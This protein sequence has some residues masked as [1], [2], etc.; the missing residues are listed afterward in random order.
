[1]ASCVFSARQIV[2]STVGWVAPWTA[3]VVLAPRF[4]VTAVAFSPDGAAVPWKARTSRSGCGTPDGEPVTGVGHE[5][6]GAAVAFS[7]R[8]SVV[9]VGSDGTVRLWACP[10]RWAAPN[11]GRPRQHVTDGSRFLPTAAAMLRL[12]GTGMLQLWTLRTGSCS[13]PW[14]PRAKVEPV[15]FSPYAA[16]VA[17]VEHGF[18]LCSFGT[19]HTGEL[20]RTWRS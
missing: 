7:P 16:I 14:P 9:S 2:D 6:S 19:P 15:T 12:A 18:T 17:S 3:H 5:Q 11:P 1:L 10:H 8:L 4:R 20:V 13:R